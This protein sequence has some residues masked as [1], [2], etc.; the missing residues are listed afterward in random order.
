MKARTL[1][2]EIMSMLGVDNIE[3]VAESYE[4]DK[5][6]SGILYFIGKP[7]G[8]LVNYLDLSLDYMQFGLYSKAVEVLDGCNESNAL[9]AIIYSLIK[10]RKC[11]SLKM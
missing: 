8:R 4:I 7:I 1:K 9:V 10:L 6:S 2:A 11:L 5:L 3:F